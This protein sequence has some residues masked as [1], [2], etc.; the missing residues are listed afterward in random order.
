MSSERWREEA[1]VL[2]HTNGAPWLDVRA[3]DWNSRMHGKDGSLYYFHFG[4]ADA[5]KSDFLGELDF[6]TFACRGPLS[7]LRLFD[8]NKSVAQVLKVRGVV[9][10]QDVITLY[11]LSPCF[12]ISHGFSV[13]HSVPTIERIKREDILRGL[14]NEVIKS[15]FGSNVV[16]FRRRSEVR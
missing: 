9:S 8:Y 2:I 5:I 7:Q 3:P 13:G 16:P 14:W 12:M 11:D 6:L 1:K 10:L 15:R 4:D